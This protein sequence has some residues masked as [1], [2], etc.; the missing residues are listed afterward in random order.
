MKIKFIISLLFV[1]A[2]SHSAMADQNSN[3]EKDREQVISRY[4]LDLQK[5]DYQDITSLFTKEGMV[6][7]TSRGNINAKDFFYSFLPNITTATTELHQLFSSDQDNN[8]RAARF[9]FGFKL[10]DGEAGQGEYVDEFTFM[11]KSAML[12]KVAM[13]ENLKFD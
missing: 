4:V 5:A 8:V 9:H 10:K 7:S 11:D 6:V 1:V 2:Y 12:V 3:L 13:F